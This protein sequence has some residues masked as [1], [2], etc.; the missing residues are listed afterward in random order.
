[1]F[2]RVTESITARC[3]KEVELIVI[4]ILENKNFLYLIY[5]Y[6]T[7]HFFL[8]VIAEGVKVRSKSDIVK[9]DID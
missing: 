4:C 1:M 3:S 6:Y 8:A 9:E 2:D 7:V 5:L